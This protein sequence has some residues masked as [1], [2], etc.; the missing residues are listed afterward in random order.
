MSDESS[1]SEFE[2]REEESSDDDDDNAKPA[3]MVSDNPVSANIR[4]T[5]EN[6]D[7]CFGAL[8]GEVNT[9]RT[10]R[11]KKIELKLGTAEDLIER[12]MSKETMSAFEVLMIAPDATDGE[13]TKMYRKV[14]RLVHPDKCQLANAHEAFQK[15]AKAYEEVKNPA[16][17]E[18][19]MDVID[20]AK[21]TVKEGREKENENRAKE[22]LELLLM[23]GPD[24]DRAVVHECEKMLNICVEKASYAETVRAKNEARIEAVQKERKKQQ[25][26]VSSDKKK[27]EVN[28]DKRVAGW[29]IFR[30]NVEAKKFKNMSSGRI[31]V[32]GSADR[33]H[34]REERTELE[35]EQKLKD[36][37]KDRPAG[38]D[39]SFKT[40]WR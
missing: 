38:V 35:E 18:R 25:R 5:K 15:V 31:G 14:S 36:G 40:N 23:E 20:K 26:E 21:Q 2:I 16:T 24:F 13:I 10:A 34:T 30:N 1:E 4:T 28:R 33:F 19:Y 7:D 37:T 6:L 11:G 32:L 27:W 9:L 12:L 29:Q 8:L 39:A 17:K 22:G 3:W